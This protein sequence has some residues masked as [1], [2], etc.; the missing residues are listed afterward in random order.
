M[1]TSSLHIYSFFTHLRCSGVWRLV[2]GTQVRRRCDYWLRRGKG[3]SRQCRV[4]VGTTS[5][6]RS[7]HKRQSAASHDLGRSGPRCM[8]ACHKSHIRKW[9]TQHDIWSS[10]LDIHLN[11]LMQFVR[12]SNLPIVDH[13]QDRIIPKL[14][15]N[16]SLSWNNTWLGQH[17]HT[18]T[19]N[20]LEAG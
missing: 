2:N 8:R 9:W 15:N 12:Q 13:I 14:R 3:E 17:G 19:F 16:S 6:L 4:P 10:R 5:V 1:M 18:E 7:T 11:S 20:Q